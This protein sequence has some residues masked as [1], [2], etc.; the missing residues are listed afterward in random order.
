MF[1]IHRMKCYVIQK[2]ERFEISKWL[3]DSVASFR[4]DECDWINMFE[5]CD[6]EKKISSL[7]LSLIE[8]DLNC[9]QIE[10]DS[11]SDTDWIKC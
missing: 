4:V 1:P 6:A 7:L 5:L 8:K 9:I 3:T 11:G 2:K 10:I